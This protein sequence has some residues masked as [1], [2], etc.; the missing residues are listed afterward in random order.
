MQPL[1]DALQSVQARPLTD[2]DAFEAGRRLPRPMLA[3]NFEPVSERCFIGPNFVRSVVSHAGW[4]WRAEGHWMTPKYGFIATEP[5]KVLRLRLNST[6]ATGR[7]DET[8]R[9]LG[10][11][12]STRLVGV[13]MGP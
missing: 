11:A 13:C 10:A 6:S 2:A 9:G 5:G 3:D 7:G 12:L 4:E 8:V 1:L